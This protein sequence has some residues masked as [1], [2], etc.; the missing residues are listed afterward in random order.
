MTPY[1]FKSRFLAS[2]PPLPDDIDLLLDQFVSFPPELAAKLNIAEA[3]RQ[4]L[5]ESGLPADAAPFLSFGLSVG[6]VLQPLTEFPDSVAIGHNGSGDLICLDQSDVG[7]VV[8]YNHDNHM[9][10]VFM[11]SSL[12]QFA[13]CLCFFARFMQTK[14]ANEFISRVR[15]IDPAALG[16]GAFWPNEVRCEIDA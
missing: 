7:A 13:E 15:E 3:D 5:I 1:E 2:L 9:Q 16:H 14:D 12:I 6:R 10:R 4:L 11:N 8:Y